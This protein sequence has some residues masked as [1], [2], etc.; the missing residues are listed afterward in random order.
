MTPTPTTD[1]S[2]WGQET[3]VPESKSAA[4]VK[5]DE[6]IFSEDSPNAEGDGQYDTA[7]SVAARVCGFGVNREKA[8]ELLSD[9]NALACTP[10]L[11][12]ADIRSAVQT[13]YSDRKRGGSTELTPHEASK[14]TLG[15]ARAACVPPPSK[16]EAAL[17]AAR[18]GF[19]VFPLKHYVPPAE[20]TAEA[21]E[22]AIKEAKKPVDGFDRWQFRA[23]TDEAQIRRWWTRWPHAN[24]AGVTEGRLAVDVD[25]KNGGDDTYAELSLTNDF[26]NTLRTKTPSGG[27]HHIYTMPEHVSVRGSVGEIGLGIDIRASGNY[28]VLPGST[29]EGRPYEWANDAPM[30][31]A[32]QWLIAACKKPK[33]K[34]ANAGKRVVEED[35]TSIEL[36]KKYLTHRAPVANEGT[37]NN[38]AVV[39]ANGLYDY[40]V[41]KETCVELLWQWNE[42]HCF[43][44]LGD[45]AELEQVAASA[46]GSRINP[47][48]CSHPLAPG[49][50]DES[51]SMKPLTPAQQ[52][53]QLERQ[54]ACKTEPEREATRNTVSDEKPKH[55]R[56]AT[57]VE[58]FE[59]T[60]LPPRPWILT[61]FACRN[62]VSIIT[63]LSGASKSTYSFPL[64]LAT[65]TGRDDIAGFHVQ[66][67]SRVWMWN[68]EDDMQEMRRRLLA[69]MKTFDVS[70][71]DLRDENGEPMLYMDSGVD[72]PMMLA[73]KRANAVR[74]T[75]DL[76][77]V[78]DTVR[79]RKIGLL[80][81][82]PLVEFH[83]ADENANMEMRAVIGCVRSI[84]VGTECAAVVVA[85]TG[86]PSRASSKSYAGDPN[87]IRGAYAQVGTARIVATVHPAAKEDEKEWILPGGFDEYVRVDVAKNNL[88]PR[89]TVWL[90]REV[91]MIGGERVA[92]VRPVVLEAKIKAG[93]TDLL[94]TVA[95]AIRDHLDPGKPYPLSQIA[96][97]LPAA[98]A[99]VLR[100][101]NRSRTVKEAFGGEGVVEYL[102]NFGVLRQTKAAGSKG[103]L[104]ALI[105]SHQPHQNAIDEML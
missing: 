39:V 31:L 80:M 9:W 18:R 59:E 27:N 99:A 84:A 25:P 37:R 95:Q 75:D 56:N 71:D 20:D 102:T 3:T 72:A 34:G 2:L 48:G 62:L 81:L 89:P 104:L 45:P 22:H 92:M 100:H 35:D 64:A 61:N 21:R 78:I 33:P 38:T 79:E 97:R 98:E 82:D 52:E 14:R 94:E 10:G 77:A 101:T 55:V 29:Y 26:P 40:G 36:A 91:Q 11:C 46:P 53:E 74:G 70:W 87:S 68:Q 41:S 86:K 6:W 83:E 90:K 51:E 32:P 76:A 65:I 66:E 12:P 13:A 15:E 54:K 4:V 73:I 69:A 19:S 17:D 67:R 105:P 58:P 103:I 24:I 5:A 93:K 8:V 50:T 16:L 49:F 44:P 47:I 42:T 30:A 23:T 43:P 57:P 88:G 60:S 96:E 63:G 28:V 1:L 7:V 85:H